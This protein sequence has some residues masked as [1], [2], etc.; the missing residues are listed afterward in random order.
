V[1]YED[2]HLKFA[3]RSFAIQG[4]Q[5]SEIIE[6]ER[7]FPDAPRITAGWRELPSWEQAFTPRL[8]MPPAA[9]AQRRERE[10]D[11]ISQRVVTGLRSLS[12]VARDDPSIGTSLVLQLRLRNDS[13]NAGKKTKRFTP[14]AD[15]QM[16]SQS[17]PF[18]SLDSVVAMLAVEGGFVCVRSKHR[19]ATDR[20]R[21][22]VYCI[23][24]GPTYSVLIDCPP[25]ASGIAVTT[26][27]CC[28]H[29]FI[30]QIPPTD[31][32][33]KTW[34]LTNPSVDLDRIYRAQHPLRVIARALLKGHSLTCLAHRLL[35]AGWIESIPTVHHGLAIR[36]EPPCLEALL[37]G[38]D[39][40]LSLICTGDLGTGLKYNGQ[41]VV[42]LA[43][44]APWAM[45]CLSHHCQFLELDCSFEALPP[46]AYSIPMAVKANRG[47]PLGIIVAPSERETMFEVFRELVLERGVREE[48]FLGRPLLS[49]EG[50]ALQAYGCCHI[51]HFYCMRHLLEG[52]GSGTLA[53]L[54]ARRLLFTRTEFEF[55]EL[56]DQ[57]L[58]DFTVACSLQRITQKAQAKFRRIFGIGPEAEPPLTV[59][60]TLV[61]CHALWGERGLHYGVASCTNHV[62][63][64]HGRLNAATASFQNPERRLAI[65]IDMIRQSAATWAQ[66]VGK[67]RGKALKKVAEMAKREIHVARCESP[68][69]DKG[70]ILSHRYEIAF[71]CM[72]VA[73]PSLE[74]VALQPVQFPLVDDKSPTITVRALQSDERPWPFAAGRR[75]GGKMTDEEFRAPPGD[76]IQQFIAR[77]RHELRYLNHGN[78]F[79]YHRDQMLFRLGQIHGCDS[80]SKQEREAANS[81]FL[82]ECLEVLENKRRWE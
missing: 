15:A 61:R 17:H 19:A 4:Q 47:I 28:S 53:A 18:C 1:Q 27:R 3:R 42:L 39:G 30:G 72:H 9:L 5:F 22:Q 12:V 64:L 78:E 2:F 62:E 58:S 51:R 46:Y 69:C 26:Q 41:T 34:F 67:S 23:V 80:R 21:F 81:A 65:I 63:G 44:V 76:E 31:S 59:N 7:Y 55:L 13:G 35:L 33:S 73:S 10:R 57:T 25:D 66:R 6:R 16:R 75:K 45:R 52:L 50:K 20:F 56:V 43:W 32:R 38:F 54:L 49:D 40:A 11:E 79:P 24:C 36:D 82:I 77:L 14:F 60:M 8:A 48:E 70:A 68:R 74:G 37:Q 71:P 29:F